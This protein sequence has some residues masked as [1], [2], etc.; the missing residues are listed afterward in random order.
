MGEHYTRNAFECTAWCNRCRRDTQHRVDGG[1]RGP[2]L[3]CIKKRELEN[4]VNRI[5]RP[6]GWPAVRLTVYDA[7]TAVRIDGKTADGQEVVALCM[8]MR[9]DKVGPFAQ[10]PHEVKKEAKAEQEATTAV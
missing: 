8:P 9:L 6:V 4:E 1:R 2:C 7:Q 10:R 5:K 3:E